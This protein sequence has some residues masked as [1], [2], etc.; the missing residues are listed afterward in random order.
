MASISTNNADRKHAVIKAL[1]HLA[2][3][4]AVLLLAQTFG[5]TATNQPPPPLPPGTVKNIVLVHG[6]W[7]DGSS[8]AKVIPL[9]QAKGYQVTA[10]QNPLTSLADDI[11]ATRRAI[12]LQDGPCILVGHSYGGAVITGAGTDPKV[13]GLVYVSAFAPDVGQSALDEGKAFPAPP[14]STEIRPDGSGFLTLTFK[15]VSEDFVPDQPALEQ[16]IA[17]VTQGATGVAALGGKETD[18]AWKTKPAWF[19]IA[20]NDRMIPPEEERARAA[21][22]KADSTELPSGHVPML[23]H[24]EDVA[25]VIERA[26]TTAASRASGSGQ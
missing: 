23:S 3:A 24:P 12:A 21:A 19:I 11:A 16:Q 20:A 18:A 7:A 5:C 13:V 9:L 25:D 17:F 10:V 15:G 14:V 6:A 2:H 4:V 26:A 8:W 22:I 1:R